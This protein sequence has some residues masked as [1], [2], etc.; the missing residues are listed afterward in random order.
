[1][2][3]AV[4][5]PP[6]DEYSTPDDALTFQQFWEADDAVSHIL[7]AKL[8]DNVLN[9]IPD[10]R[11]PPHGFST[12]TA[13]DIYTILTHHFSVASATTA[14]ALCNKLHNLKTLP[15]GIPAY[16]AIW[17]ASVPQ[18]AQTEWDMLPYNRVQGFLDGL[19][20]LAS[21][22]PI[23]EEVRKSWQQKGKDVLASILNQFNAILDSGCT[24]HIIHDHKWFW[25]YHPELAVPIGTANCGQ[26][27]ETK[28]C[29]KVRFHVHIDGKTIIICLPDC[30][31]A[32]DMP[33]NLLSISLM[34]ENKL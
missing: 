6:Y 8:H 9:S 11:G 5:P 7:T 29:G 21:F 16:I 18:L 15:N 24:T 31:H 12:T 25:T 1:M 26:V 34:V 27:L 28:A 13:W 20:P 33:I 32:P 30:L 14:K 2:S 3:I 22:A 10:K 4:V 19:P 17:R 23:C